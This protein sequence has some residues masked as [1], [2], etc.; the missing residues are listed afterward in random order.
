MPI[1][2]MLRSLRPDPTE[3]LTP[4]TPHEAITVGARVVIP[5]GRTVHSDD[6]D[7]PH[8]YL[9][10]P[11]I[12]TVTDIIETDD[13]D[14]LLAYN[15]NAGTWTALIDEQVR[16]ANQLTATATTSDRSIADRDRD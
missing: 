5:A 8:W 2:M 13:G 9:S 12:V 4:A 7:L 1:K 11:S 14:Q 10:E 3:E 16:A 15:G 6:P